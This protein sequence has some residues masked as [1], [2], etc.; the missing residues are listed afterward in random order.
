MGLRL[1]LTIILYMFIV[2]ILEK[3]PIEYTVGDI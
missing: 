2:I 1:D 3:T